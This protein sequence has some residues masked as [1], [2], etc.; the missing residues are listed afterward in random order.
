MANFIESLVLRLTKGSEITASEYDAN[1]TAIATQIDK[2]KVVGNTAPTNVNEPAGALGEV[3]VSGNNLYIHNGTEWRNYSS[4]SIIPLVFA[5]LDL[6][7]DGGDDALVWNVE[8]EVSSDITYYKVYNVT[9]T[10]EVGSQI[11]VGGGS[12]S[13]LSGSVSLVSG[14]EYLIRAYD[15]GDTL[16]KTSLDDGISNIT[17][18]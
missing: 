17:K 6:S 15:G 2:F 3:I 18:P 10:V 11:A 16:V 13:S 7:Y 9:D 4:S 12:Y 5:F 14:K 1:L 8:N